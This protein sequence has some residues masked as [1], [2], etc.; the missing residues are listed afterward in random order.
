MEEKNNQKEK[1][2][3]LND[4][5]QMM[6]GGFKRVD[7]RFEESRK[8]TKKLIDEKIEWLARNTQDNFLSIEGKLDGVE[9]RLGK[10]ETGMEDIKANL[11]KKVDRFEHKDLEIRVEKME[12][13]FKLKQRLKFA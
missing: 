2:L 1:E 12:E 5:A 4:L 3:T 7:K 8:Y 9:G 10:I 6:E 13:K 11:N